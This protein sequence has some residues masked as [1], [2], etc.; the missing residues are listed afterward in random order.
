MGY[1]YRDECQG[2]LGC[3]E[4][5]MEVIIVPLWQIAEIVGILCLI[6]LAL[7]ATVFFVDFMLV[8]IRAW[9]L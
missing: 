5:L 8:I 4:G 2:W 3:V 6:G 9:R 7:S 1:H